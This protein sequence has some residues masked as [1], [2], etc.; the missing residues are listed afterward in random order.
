[1]KQLTKLGWVILSIAG[2]NYGIESYKGYQLKSQID[3]IK[4]TS[5]DSLAQNSYTNIARGIHTAE[6][7]YDRNRRI[8]KSI[9]NE[10]EIHLLMK[11]YG[12]P[13]IDFIDFTGSKGI[14]DKTGISLDFDM[15]ENDLRNELV[16]QMGIYKKLKE[17]DDWK[18][19]LSKFF[20]NKK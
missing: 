19:K 9:L 8:L 11:K 16:N 17:E 3:S 10:P 13:T 7:R 14:T 6:T 2:I 12:Y 4:Y 1:M 5:L 15:K 18:R 20:G